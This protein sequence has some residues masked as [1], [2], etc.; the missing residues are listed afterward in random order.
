MFYGRTAEIAALDDLLT[1]VTTGRAGIAVLRG[2]AGIGKSALLTHTAETA[3]KF[4]IDSAAAET[5]GRDRPTGPPP[6]VD[7]T[8]SGGAAAGS[9]ARRG[10]VSGFRVL[11]VT[12]TEA[13]SALPYAGLHLLFGKARRELDALPAAQADALRAA[14]DS[15]AGVGNPFLVSAATLTLLADLAEAQPLLCLIDDA[16]WVDRASLDALLFAARRL[17][18][19]PIALIF[20]VRDDHLP[21]LQQLDAR[22]LFLTGL[23]TPDAET[24][25]TTH[26][27]D[28]TPATAHW[29]V[30][31]SHGNPLALQVLPT[32]QRSGDMYESPYH[33]SPTPTRIQRAFTDQIARL[34]PEVRDL[35]LIAAA[36]SSGEAAVIRTAAS[37]LTHTREAT[38]AGQVGAAEL[39]AE[40]AG[41]L[42]LEG[43][44]ILFRHPLIRAAAYQGASAA[45]R[46]AAHR[47][48]AGAFADSCDDRRAWHLA[49]AAT[50]ADEAAAG[51]LEQAAVCAR[52]RGG[53][54]ETSAAYERAA[55]LSPA[56]ADS[57]RRAGAAAQAAAD[58]GDLDRAA[59]LVESAIAALPQEYEQAHS[60]S[61]QA[62]AG[63]ES[64]GADASSVAFATGSDPA[65][66]GLPAESGLFARLVSLRATIERDQDR[67]RTA[68]R[69]LTSAAVATAGTEPETASLLLFQA[70]ESAWAAGDLDAVRRAAA[71]TEQLELP[72]GER[73]AALVDLLDALNLEPG[74]Q[75]RGAAAVRELLAGLSP[76]RLRERAQVVHWQLLLGDQHA[77]RE[78]A[79]ALE[80][81]CRRDGALG[82]LA[83]TL[84]LRAR[85]EILLGNLAQ[86]EAAATEG[87]RLAGDIGQRNLH[88]RY[89]AALA[90]LAAL[91]GEE[92]ACRE[93][94]SA[95][96][97][98]GIAPASVHADAALGLLELGLGRPEAAF[99]RY[100]TMLAS[101]NRHGATASL[102]DLIEAA[103]RIGRTA[104]ARPALDSYTAWAERARHPWALAVAHRCHALLADGDSPGWWP[105]GTGP[106]TAGT[107]AEQHFRAALELHYG[108]A[109]YTFERART[110]LLYGE[111]LRREQRRA[112]ARRHLRAAMESFERLDAR[113]WAERARAELRATGETRTAAPAADV[114]TTLTPQELQSVQLAAEGLSNKDIAARLFLSPR[115]VG[116]HLSNAYPKLG[117]SSRRELAAFRDLTAAH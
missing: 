43:D 20:A 39:A 31:E 109:E 64:G 32:L 52:G 96:L 41:L 66:L 87:L 26:H 27:P 86:A 21:E 15:G 99:D 94:T 97:A 95:P 33:H 117:I 53:L 48:L 55:V 1:R 30:R 100:L 14:L 35:L 44:R 51:A 113:P 47:A 69:S 24:L 108:T 71:L 74:S 98:H 112:D 80:D 59:A 93:L 36:D 9:W 103:H 107:P 56:A 6:N 12:G 63:R 62:A 42:R 70:A 46:R 25:L 114:L 57:S 92:T 85:I 78:L 2:E 54:R 67:P 10:P 40:R 28:L 23:A 75:D 90:H 4:R 16:Q 76:N 116:Y 5:A 89:A 110:E 34:T 105:S 72:R 38:D 29:I 73:I 37:L 7:R 61:A 19:E 17:D 58:A 45:E 18:A 50:G 88:D 65:T 83:L 81:D 115:T 13:E 11:R 77:A 104:D 3:A 82:V 101:A 8:G 106:D 68:Y 49:A 91:R 22:E 60:D 111:W 102:P 79:A 84:W